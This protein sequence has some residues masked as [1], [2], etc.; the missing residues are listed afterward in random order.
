MSKVLRILGSLALL[1]FIA[2]RLDWDQL[3]GAF[4]RVDY[5]LW[6]AA[7]GVYVF[8]QV[9]SSL[10]WQLL[11]QPLGF[12]LGLARYISLYFIGMFFNLV[13][14]TSVGGD[15]VRAG[16][17]ATG[18]RRRGAAVLSVLVDR[19]T[20]LVVL[21]AMACIAGLFVRGMMPPWMGATLL[22]MAALLVGGM[23]CVPLLPRISRWRFLGKRGAQ[24]AMVGEVYLRRPKVL[25]IAVAL[26]LVVQVAGVVYTGLIAW[27]M[28][29][30]V[31]WSYLA[32]VVPLVALLTLLPVSINGMGLRE[33]GLVVLLGPVGVPA[34]SAVTLSLL[35]F[36]ATFA[37]SLLGAGF[38][39]GGA[40]PRLESTPAMD[41]KTEGRSDVEAIRGNS[42]QGRAGQSA[43]AA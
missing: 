25:A 20:G 6:V 26:S 43:K 23:A 8:A 21:I 11:S 28:G 38:Y 17:L 41:R 40:Y 42:D 22:G 32:V 19:G 36:A 7:V 14:P 2:W 31:S 33:V 24:L 1:A 29:L 30:D 37:A 35:S 18:T 15:V 10:R 12:D 5:A 16:Y 13:L 27:A 9:V 4:A 39:L 34:A 3:G